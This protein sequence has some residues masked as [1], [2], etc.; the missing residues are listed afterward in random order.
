MYYGLGRVQFG[1]ATR[2]VFM[3]CPPCSYL[4]EGTCVVCD[5]A[6]E[7]PACQHCVAGQYQPPK[8]SWYESELLLAVMTATVVS[9]AS[10][11]VVSRVNRLLAKRDKAKGKA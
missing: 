4:V 6:D 8:P 11:I 1:Q 3:S 10:A 5:P 7:H 9:V 2:Q